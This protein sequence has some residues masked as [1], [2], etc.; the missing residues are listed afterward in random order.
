MIAIYIFYNSTFAVVKLLAIPVPIMQREHEIGLQINSA[1][2]AQEMKDLATNF[3]LRIIILRLYM[4][5]KNG[6]EEISI[7]LVVSS[8]LDY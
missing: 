5:A 8:N 2:I 6:Q 1:R 3:S 7:S 4:E